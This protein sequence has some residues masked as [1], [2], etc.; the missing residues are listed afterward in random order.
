MPIE[1]RGWRMLCGQT[2]GGSPVSRDWI[3][4]GL[5]VGLLICWSIVNFSFGLDHTP[6][7]GLYL[8]AGAQGYVRSLAT[9]T[10]TNYAPGFPWL[11][12]TAMIL[13]SLPGNA[14]ILVQAASIATVTLGTYYLVRSTGGNI[15]LGTA[16]AVLMGFFPS[17]AYVF[18]IQL[19][20]GPLCA[21]LVALIV[22]WSRCLSRGGLGWRVALLSLASAAPFIKYGAILVP[23]VTAV[24]LACVER[25]FRVR[26]FFRMA[27]YATL[28]MLPIAGYF[29]WNRTREG[30]LTA[31][32]AARVG[33]V[34][35]VQ[36]VL[37]T[38]ADTFWGWPL[39]LVG[40]A[41]I[42]VVWGVK[43]RIILH[44][45]HAGVAL[46]AAVVAAAYLTGI[47]IGASLVHVDP[48]TTRLCAPGIAALVLALAQATSS[49]I[50]TFGEGRTR[51]ILSVMSTAAALIAVSGP[52]V[53]TVARPMRLLARGKRTKVE[54][55]FD[56]G[57]RRSKGI[58]GLRRFYEM[59]LASA[60]ELSVTL[61]EA[62]RSPGKIRRGWMMMAG[63]L[64]N[65]PTSLQNF[66]RLR[67]KD[68]SETSVRYAWG[69]HDNE[70]LFL[71]ADMP[72][73]RG[74]GADV[75]LDDFVS[76]VVER[77]VKDARAAGRTE[78]WLLVPKQ[79]RWFTAQQGNLGG[80]PV[81]REQEA[82]T[83]RAY[84]LRT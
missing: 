19:S 18:A 59:E 26:N 35:N 31:H 68:I 2:I 51:R 67:L 34:E 8:Y 36:T 66:G 62:R 52:I 32:P 25:P 38:I 56:G 13:C 72:E 14:A 11:I 65:T 74:L 78:H 41:L 40:V 50:A 4:V 45:L 22:V 71:N 80:V 61:V 6:D 64:G 7:S 23:F 37:A 17:T 42:I 12:S 54:F 81:L 15:F 21:L 73:S 44:I 27:L 1:R 60:K 30:R 28:S 49:L 3:A 39:I 82:G 24:C 46:F 20:E 53:E 76:T 47:V 58:V 43:H 83:Y 69:E 84:L 57:F 16:F 5:I 79:A 77:V 9:S 10:P 75:S 55:N 70:I 48:L 63:V 29:L 33:I